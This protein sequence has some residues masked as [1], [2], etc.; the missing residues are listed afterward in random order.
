MYRVFLIFLY[1]NIN[2]NVFSSNK[3]LN[4]CGSNNSKTEL[5]NEYVIKEEINNN[6]ICEKSKIVEEKKIKY[7][8]SNNREIFLDVKFKNF[9]D[10]FK[11][12]FDNNKNYEYIYN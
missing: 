6:F 9:V 4:C 2:I 11:K 10:D 12:K 7:I 5:V 3:R 1:L 8:L